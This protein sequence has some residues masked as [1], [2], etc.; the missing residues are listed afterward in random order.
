MMKK[1][2][3]ISLAVFGL[4]LA[5][6]VFVTTRKPERGMTRLSFADVKVDGADRITITGKNPVELVKRDGVWRLANGKL[7]DAG[8]VTRLLESVPKMKSNDLLSADASKL[9]ELELDAE[10]GSAVT[11]FAGKQKL[12]GF[13][14][15]K[16]VPGGLALS[17]DAGVFKVAG[18]AAMNYSKPAA[19]WLEHKLFADKQDD[20]TRLEVRLA[21]ERPYALVKKDNAWAPED[22]KA[23]PPG[24]R[25]DADAARSLVAGVVNARVKDFE[26]TDPGAP[27]TGL[28]DK[29]D[30]ISFVVAPAAPAPTDDAMKV[31]VAAAPAP[32]AEA[33]KADAVAAPAPRAEAAKAD[34][35]V[36]PAPVTRTLR[37][38]AV[39]PGDAK[40]VYARIDGKDELFTLADYTV[41]SLRKALVDLRDLKLMSFERATV[42]KLNIVD[43]K[44]NL[45][46]EKKNN[47][48]SLVK[49]AEP[50]PADFELDPSAV[51]RRLSGI[52]SAR[53][54]KVVVGNTRGDPGLA[55]AKAKVTVT[56]KGGATVTLAFGNTT[57]DDDREV[58]FAKG[59]ADGAVYFVPKW[60][61]DNLLGGLATFK[62]QATQGGG[63]EGI[64]PKALSNLPPDVRESLM[65][66]IEQKK[67]EQE[68]LKRLQQQAH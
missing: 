54:T 5:M 2:T 51:E 6:A 35:V 22:S 64:D 40:D 21:G 28:S 50:K 61:R 34:A 37:L 57:K 30:V 68:M 13:T 3:L 8:A 33:A 32:G 43:G 60:T 55:A 66:Q 58:S 26:E 20:V 11:V 29:S 44:V 25:F 15:G 42:E 24:F 52:A 59:N 7:A 67:R 41:K 1:S 4:L 10:K 9:T 38:G 39:K 19:T 65:K 27:K 17:T 16:S 47:V 46:F 49:S 56:Q 23:L 53:G 12:A 31:D 36:A 63:F 14:V 45:A 48:W 62:T 18:V